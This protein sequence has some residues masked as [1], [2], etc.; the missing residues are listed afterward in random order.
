MVCGLPQAG[1]AD[2]RDSVPKG[3]TQCVEMS[4]A[5]HAGVTRLF[6]LQARHIRDS[7]LP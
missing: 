1:P 6:V 3:R 7:C 5:F 4:L 2:R